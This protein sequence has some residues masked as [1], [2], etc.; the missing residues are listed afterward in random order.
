MARTVWLGALAAL[1]VGC[2]QGMT[3]DDDDGN[4][5]KWPIAS[6]DGGAG[7]TA[8]GG[9]SS[10][11][12]TTSTGHAASSSSSGAGGSGCDGQGDCNTCANCS[13]TNVCA[14]EVNACTA[15]V[16]C[17][18]YVDCLSLCQ[19]QPCLDAC[20]SQHPTGVTLYMAVAECAFCT[21]CPLDCAIEGQGV[22]GI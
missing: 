4:K 15:N 20:A 12:S 22:C 18:D 8:N 7:G 5:G 10:V 6:G 2:A 11:S 1:A 9:A 19:D 21:A 17:T 3:G 14:A 13:L 16:D